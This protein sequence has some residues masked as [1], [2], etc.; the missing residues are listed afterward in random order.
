MEK[1]LAILYQEIGTKLNDIIPG[2][3]DEIYYLGEVENQKKSYSS[4]FYFKVDNFIFRATE[5]PN[6]YNVSEE[7]FDTLMN[8][9]NETLLKLYDCFDKYEQS[10]WEQLHIKLSSDGKI[11]V[12][13]E[14]DAFSPTDEGQVGREVIWANN[15]FGYMPAE[16]TYESKI[17]NKYLEKRV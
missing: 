1:E 8:E 4:I 10:L 3:W 17:L 15:T 7:I 9:L 16:G 5:I 12:H 14:Y 13:F 11:N 2:R 6:K